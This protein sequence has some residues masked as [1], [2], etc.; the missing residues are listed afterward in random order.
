MRPDNVLVLALEKLILNM[1]NEHF[2][3]HVTQQVFRKYAS[4]DEFV[5]IRDKMVFSYAKFYF[6]Y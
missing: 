2:L 5:L 6:W 1:M 4:N 3:T